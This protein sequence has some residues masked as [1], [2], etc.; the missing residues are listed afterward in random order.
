MYVE[1]HCHKQVALRLKMTASIIREAHLLNES[2][3]IQA[4]IGLWK[5]EC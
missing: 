3:G 4:G 2:I 1:W 5:D